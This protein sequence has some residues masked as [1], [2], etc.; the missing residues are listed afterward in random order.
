[1]IGQT[2]K[3]CCLLLLIS[4]SFGA[5]LRNWKRASLLGCHFG[6]CSMIVS[7][8]R[9]PRTVLWNSGGRYDKAIA[10]FKTMQELF[11]ENNEAS[12]FPSKRRTRS[13]KPREAS[14]NVEYYIFDV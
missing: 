2:L 12:S 4:S 11:D 1:M 5:S 13:E 14:R 10:H 7:A 8:L 9:D 6:D 3:I